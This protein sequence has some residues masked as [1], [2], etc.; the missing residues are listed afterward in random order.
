MQ[1]EDMTPT[2]FGLAVRSDIQ[3]L[4]VT[5]R[6][7]MRSAKDY[8]TVVNFSGEVVETKYVHST[9]DIL[10]RN[11]EVTSTFLSD[12]QNTYPVRQGETPADP[13]CKKGSCYGFPAWFCCPHHEHC[14][15]L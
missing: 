14:Y 4:L 9:V 6:N 2:D 3:G 1:N 7:K 8:E 11:Y 13:W 12:L 10:R 5:A 15:G